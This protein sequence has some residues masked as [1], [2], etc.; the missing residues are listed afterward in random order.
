MEWRWGAEEQSAFDSVEERITT[1]LIL[2]LP[3]NLRPFRIEAELGFR[4]RCRIVS[5]IARRQQMASHSIPFQIP[6][7][8]GAEL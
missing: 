5:T 4:N 2:A 8:G 1:A 3:D 7:S 6:F